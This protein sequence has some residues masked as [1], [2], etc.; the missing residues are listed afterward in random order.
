MVSKQVPVRTFADWRGQLRAIRQLILMAKI[1]AVRKEIYV[2][3][4]EFDVQAMRKNT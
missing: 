4:V 1:P 3:R 2:K